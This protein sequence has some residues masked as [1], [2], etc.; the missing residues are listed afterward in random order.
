MFQLHR[1]LKKRFIFVFYKYTQPVYNLFSPHRS[2][3]RWW[4]NI[5]EDNILFNLQV[6]TVMWAAGFDGSSIYI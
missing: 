2:E 1:A 3:H 6:F 4:R 5:L